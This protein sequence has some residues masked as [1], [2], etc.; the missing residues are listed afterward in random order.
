MNNIEQIVR[1]ALC[2][3]LKRPESESQAIQL[4]S[5]LQYDYGL[6]SL[7]LIMMMTSLCK[8]V[9]VALT[10]FNEDDLAGLRRPS[11]LVNLLTAKAVA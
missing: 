1:Q 8:E 5:D 6:S 7:E 4:D 9:G 2:G 11:D 10:D 3:V